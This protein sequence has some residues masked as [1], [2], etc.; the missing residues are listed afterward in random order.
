MLNVVYLFIFFKK[1]SQGFPEKKSATEAP[2][3]QKF[4][5]LLLTTGCTYFW[6]LNAPTGL[7]GW[8]DFLF[9]FFFSPMFKQKLAVVQ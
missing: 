1:A 6:N 8:S 5:V 4:T 9:I 3:V 7:N 2:F